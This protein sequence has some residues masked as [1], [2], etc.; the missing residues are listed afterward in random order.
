MVTL[1]LKDLER[2]AKDEIGASPSISTEIRD[3]ASEAGS[4]FMNSRQWCWAEGRS[5][6]LRPRARILLVGATWTEATRTLTKVGAFASYSFL[7]ADVAIVTDGTGATVGTYEVES[8]TDSDSI[9]L[10][11]SIGSAAD[12][13]TDIEAGLPNDQ[14]NLPSDFDLQQITAYQ[15]GN[16]LIGL[17]EFTTAQGMLDLRTWNTHGSSIGFWALLR[18]VRS[19][20]GGQPIPRLELWP[21]AGSDA[22]ALTIFY[23][24]GWKDPATDEEILSIPAWCSGL[25][26]EFFRAVVMGR[27]EPEGG[28]V[29]ERIGAVRSGILWTDAVLRDGAMQPDMG[30]ARN[31]WM[32]G[33]GSRISRFDV[34]GPIVQV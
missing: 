9:V 10:V 6:T 30:F 14:I 15:A 8:K 24:G 7:S 31:C 29:S 12:G 4:H 16:G 1:S 2:F 3:L 18:H 5:V 17:M 20:A 26:L 32:D 22:E 23:R 33:Y 28:S 25:F 21:Q 11:T 27:E 19:N 13:Q 34:P